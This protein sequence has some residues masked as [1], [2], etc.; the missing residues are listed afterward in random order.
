MGAE[1]VKVEQIGGDPFRGMLS[2]LGAARVNGGKRS[3]SVNL[4]TERGRELVMTLVRD[5][6]VVIHNYRPGV[7]ERLGFGYDQVAAVNPRVVY[8]KARATVPMGRAQ[9]GQVPTQSPAP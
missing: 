5:A 2:G 1:V 7:P 4:K 6:D 8:L 9:R 3:V